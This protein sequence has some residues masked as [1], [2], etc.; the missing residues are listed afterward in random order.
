M[1]YLD[2]MNTVCYNLQFDGKLLKQGLTQHG[3]DIDC[4]GKEDPTYTT[5]TTMH[6]SS[7]YGAAG[8]HQSYSGSSIHDAV[9][10]DR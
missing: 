1:M 10:L 2:N 7:S 3:G 8:S 9:H 4:L 5:R 6:A